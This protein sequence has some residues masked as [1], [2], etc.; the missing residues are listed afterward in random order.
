MLSTGIGL[1]GSPLEARL[2]L[3]TGFRL[4]RSSVAVVVLTFSDYLWS[5]FLFLSRCA[6]SSL[7]Y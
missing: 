1:P 6:I 3:C 2:L 7:H 4:E 5:P